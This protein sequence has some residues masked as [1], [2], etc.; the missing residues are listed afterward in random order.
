MLQETNARITELKR[1]AYEFKRD[2]VVAGESM[3]TGKT[4]AE[5]IIRYMEEKIRQRDASI[6]KLRLKNTTIKSK[7][8][9]IESQL[10]QKEEMGDV[11]HYIDFH[12]L[13]I[14]NAQF[15]ERIEGRNGDLLR[16]KV[17]TGW[18]LHSLIKIKLRLSDLL[19]KLNWLYDEIDTRS[20]QLQ[21]ISRIAS[22]DSANCASKSQ[23]KLE[24]T[25]VEY[26]HIPATLDYVRQKVRAD[27]FCI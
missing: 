13:Q 10:E 5:S 24:K 3:R 9:K 18:T 12:Q 19:H 11:L 8:Q 17:G 16:L 26:K 6:E 14:E 23:V 15:Q 4:M 20:W 25:Q 1:E 27:S 21:S 22:R 7:L 2:V